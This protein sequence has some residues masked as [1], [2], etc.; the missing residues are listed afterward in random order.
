MFCV[1]CGKE[2]P[3]GVKFCPDC[4]ASQIVKVKPAKTKSKKKTLPKKID[5][6]KMTVSE[7]KD[8]LNKAKLPT[9]GN[10]AQLIWTLKNPNSKET[11][12]R[13][14]SKQLKAVLRRKKIPSSGPRWQLERRLTNKSVAKKAKRDMWPHHSAKK[15]RKSSSIIKKQK[16]SDAVMRSQNNDSS[17]TGLGILIGILIMVWGGYAL[18]AQ[19]SYND[20][21]DNLNEVYDENEEVL[22]AEGIGSPNAE[23]EYAACGILILGFVIFFFYYTRD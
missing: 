3:D 11:Y 10:K 18:K 21:V 22:E 7:L 19:M 1:E 8:R 13:M 5:Y 2:I 14:S 12:K 15:S 6:S 17:V 23:K 4:G 20:S 16:Y 9:G